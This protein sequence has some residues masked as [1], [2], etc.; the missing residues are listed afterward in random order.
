MANLI[1]S[2][3][4]NLLQSGYSLTSP[5]DDKYN[6][7]AWAAGATDRFWWPKSNNPAM[8]W[9]PQLPR[10]E[11][12]SN[13]ILAFQILG[14]EV[15]DDP[16]LEP[17]YEKVAIYA[18]GQGK[19]KHMARQLISGIWTSKLR[20]D[21]DINHNTLEGVEGSKYGRVVQFMKRARD[22]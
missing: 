22:D 13:F 17:R 19:P 9:P 18:D 1:E 15:C 12:V 8:H 3:F 20:P 21:V 7:I 4:P 6:C 10:E 11:T 5:S 14:Y 2:S 16:D